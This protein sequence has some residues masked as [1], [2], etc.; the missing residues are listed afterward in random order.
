[1]SGTATTLALPPAHMALPRATITIK[2]GT[3]THIRAEKSD[4]SLRN[5]AFSAPR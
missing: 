2:V 4:A 1:M 5:G 3:S